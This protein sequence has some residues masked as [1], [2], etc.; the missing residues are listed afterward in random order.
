MSKSEAQTRSELIDQ[1]LEFIRSFAEAYSDREMV[2]QL[3]SQILEAVTEDTESAEVEEH[4]IH[5]C[6]DTQTSVVI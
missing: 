6:H 4:E 2:K 5:E 1:Q 3:V